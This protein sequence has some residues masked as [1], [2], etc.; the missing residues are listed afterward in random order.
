MATSVGGLIEASDYNSI[1][2]TVDLVLGAGNAAQIGYGQTLTSSDVSVNAVVQAQ[3]M[4]NLYTD[5]FAAR[6]HQTGNP[7]AWALATEGLSAPSVDDLIGYF[8]SAIGPDGTSSSAT[9][10]LDSG[11]LDFELAAQ[12]ISND[13]Y[14]VDPGQM[15]AAIVGS[16]QRT[17]NWNGN[18][19][20]E[21]T[22]TFANADERRY[23]F[24]SGGEIRFDANLTGGTSVSGNETQTPPGTKDEI[25]QTMLN[26]MGTIK[27]SIF[28]TTSTG[29]GTGSAIGNYDLTSTYQR[30]FTKDGSGV[31]A[32][33]VYAIDARSNTADTI[34]FKVEFQ[35]NDT[36]DQTGLGA[37]VDEN[38]TGDITNTI[39][40]FRATGLVEVPNPVYT[41]NSAL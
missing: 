9:T 29:S 33:N 16:S 22:V 37:P 4:I 23:Y 35:D 25:W 21:F 31:Y 5:L 11:F 39:T 38:V 40:T 28:N 6:V 17:T 7:P 20:H 41:L 18:I 2:N 26:A 13:V 24:N 36:G 32:E 15:S 30:I 1:R 19:T 27:F 14:L 10:N 3:D 34:Q 8:A 12:E